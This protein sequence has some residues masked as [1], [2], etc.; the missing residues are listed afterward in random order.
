MHKRTKNGFVPLKS[1]QRKIGKS[2]KAGVTCKA[3]FPKTNLCLPSTVHVCRGLAKKLKLRVSG[4]RNALGSF[5]GKRTCMW[6]SGTTPSFAVAFRSNTHTLPNWRL[7]PIEETH[8]EMCNSSACKEKLSCPREQKVVSKLAQRVQR[9]C[10]GYYCGYTFKPQPVGR[11]YLRGASE[12]LNYLTAGLRDKS[13]GQQW[14]RITHRALIDLQHRCMRRTAPEEYNLAA[15]SEEHDVTSA[16][17]IRTFESQDFSGGQLLRRLEAEV[18]QKEVRECRKV[19]PVSNDPN[20]AGEMRLRQFDDLYG[21]RGD[22]REIFLLSP[23]EFLMLWE[24]VPLPKPC[25]R[26]S[27]GWDNAGTTN[28]EDQARNGS[29]RIALKL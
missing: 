11:K 18:K 8:S 2:K 5:S 28:A 20:I 12:S 24:C 13:A 7:P 9:Q 29:V 4:R 1:C 16:E 10:T 14:H 26:Q 19:L 17:F 25:K 23:W 15:N 27:N 22:N 3:D 6:Q 21:Y